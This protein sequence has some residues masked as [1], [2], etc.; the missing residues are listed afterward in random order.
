MSELFFPQ[1]IMNYEIIRIIFAVIG[2]SIAAYFDI[3]NKK[4]IP[5]LLLYSFLILSLIIVIVDYNPILLLY[6][7]GGAAIIGLIGYIF[8]RLGQLGGADVFILCSLAL[9]LPIQPTLFSEKPLIPLPFIFSIILVSGLTFMIYVLIKYTPL[10]L[11]RKEKIDKKRILYS[12]G[13]VIIFLVFLYLYTKIPVISEYYLILMGF[14][15][16]VSIYFSIFKERLM[17]SLIEK[18]PLSKIEAED[19]IAIE[20]MKK[21]IVKKYNIPR[22][23]SEKDL[24]RLKK[25]KINKYPVYTKLPMFVPFILLG[26]LISIYFGDMLYILAATSVF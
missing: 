20:Y 19:V 4:N 12:L 13:L 23:V 25:F 18:L 11:K 26:L 21:E 16:F 6:S 3:F 1:I 22:V 17:G 15:I 5:D 10:V 14:L 24:K 7:F 9:L 8:Y 2:T